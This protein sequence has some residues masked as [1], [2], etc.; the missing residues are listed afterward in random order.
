MRRN[1]IYED[2]CHDI[3]QHQYSAKVQ[4]HITAEVNVKISYSYMN[5]SSRDL[6][7]GTR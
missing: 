3:Y 1:L 4:V 5:G 2:Q 7:R 6:R